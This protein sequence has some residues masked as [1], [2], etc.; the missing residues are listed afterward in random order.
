MP[1][2]NFYTSRGFWR[3]LE[4]DRLLWE[5]GKESLGEAQ[6]PPKPLRTFQY[7]GANGSNARSRRT[8]KPPTDPP[9][10]CPTAK[11]NGLSRHK[12]NRKSFEYEDAAR[13]TLKQNPSG[14]KDRRSNLCH[15][16]SDDNIYE[17]IVCDV[18]RDNPY[19]DVKL[20]PMCLPI[21][22][23]QALKPQRNQMLQGYAN[24]VERKRF[25]TLATPKPALSA[26]GA[27]IAAA[28][29]TCTQK[30]QRTPQ[31]IN[32]IETIFDDKRGRKRVKNLG[33][34]VREETSGTESDPE[35]NSKG[36]ISK[37][38]KSCQIY[39]AGVLN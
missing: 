24:K 34:S 26:D 10:P 15:A 21:G 2:G 8:V 32:K 22:R 23:S 20:S 12:K 1:A 31:Y 37:S 28:R 6:P 5:K 4:G 7:R 11:T 36:K 3:K 19:E 18:A 25:Q 13:L 17:D 35:D 39:V 27:K 16:Y 29:R 38:L 30:I 14:G 33:I 9:P